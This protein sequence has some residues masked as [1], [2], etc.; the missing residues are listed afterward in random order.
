MWPPNFERFLKLL[1]LLG[2]IGSFLWGVFIWSDK[3]Q[4]DLRAVSMERERVAGTR[5]I[6]ATKPFLE[7]QLKLYTEATQV[8]AVMAT[9][10]DREERRR[11]TARFWRLYWGELPL[12]EDTKVE[13]AMKDLG[14]GLRASAVKEQLE[15]LSLRL[16]HACR[17]SLDR[18]WG[19]KA[20]TAGSTQ[21]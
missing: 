16:A 10:E 9:S 15:K 14:D 18:S 5:R 8:A 20:W 4:K 2:A 13:S 1:A 19:I 17:V 12:V 11:A 7:L 21:R 3:S 6:E